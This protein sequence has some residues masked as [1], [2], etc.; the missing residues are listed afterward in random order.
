MDAIKATAKAWAALIGAVATALLG[1]Y[2]DGDF[3]RV[4]TVIAAVATAVA[5]WGVPNLDPR[6]KRQRES[7]QPPD[8]GAVDI[9]TVALIAFVVIVVLALVWVVR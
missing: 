3:G 2:A 7:V 4:L 8:R 6:G 5:T 1:I 9:G